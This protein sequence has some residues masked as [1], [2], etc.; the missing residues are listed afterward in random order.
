MIS[1][2]WSRAVVAF[3]LIAAV[4]GGL[5]LSALPVKAVSLAFIDF[6][7][8]MTQGNNDSFTSQITI[9]TNERIPIDSIR[10]D[11]TGPTNAYAI[12]NP[13]GTITNQSG[14]FANIVQQGTPSYDY[15]S[16]SASGYGFASGLNTVN[17]TVDA[18][19]DCFNV[20]YTDSAW[21]FDNGSIDVTAGYYSPHYQRSGS[22]IRFS[23]VNIP[24]GATI[25]SAYLT[26][27]SRLDTEGTTARTMIVGD[28]EPDA[29]AF[30]TLAN[31]QA[32]RGT[33]VGGANNNL[34]TTAEVYWDNIGPWTPGNQ[35]TSPDI[36][37]IIQEIIDQ[38]GWTSGNHLA[39][40]WDDH[41]GRS[42]AVNYAA[43]DGYSYRGSN[44]ECPQLHV[45]YEYAGSGSYQPSW[46]NG[47]GYSGPTTLQ[48]LVTID[49]N[50]MQ[51]GSY[52]AQLSVNV[53][54]PVDSSFTRFL[55]YPY[56]F[57]LVASS[58][59]GSTIT[60]LVPAPTIS[61]GPLPRW[62]WIAIPVVIIAI[63]V[64]IWIERRSSTH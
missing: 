48:Y 63:V 15:G 41:E 20:Y 8:T 47:Y 61:N 38:P 51:I 57:N 42:D 6:P 5:F 18:N 30:S 29:A 45:E 46:E 50:P 52:S 33:D 13:N 16:S 49:T 55:S 23:N 21:G 14:Q 10:L 25:T 7:Y 40:F 36:S 34:R 24:Q 4:L 19:E 11:L 9:D 53:P 28:K 59:G 44:T 3:V 64:L 62:P 39:L 56:S 31:Y 32:R 22:G 27:T 17:L 26:F 37:S 58:G 54:A 43:R 35:Y 2:S 60:S 12:F 1:K